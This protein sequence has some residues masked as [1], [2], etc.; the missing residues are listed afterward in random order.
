MKIIVGINCVHTSGTGKGVSAY[1]IDTGI[2]PPNKFFAGRASVAYDAIKD[3]QK[4]Y[5]VVTACYRN[6]FA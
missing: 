4:V 6:W 2:F 1:I 5:K 3:G